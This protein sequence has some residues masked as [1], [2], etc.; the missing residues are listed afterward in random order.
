MSSPG[1]EL[2]HRAPVDVD[3]D[4]LVARAVVDRQQVVGRDDERARGQRVRR[5]EG[6]D[7][8]R[9]APGQHRPAVGEVVARRALRR[10]DD[11]A[12][13][14]HAA[15]LLA[16]ER[17]GEV[18]DAE[19]RLAVHGDVVHRRPRP[20]GAPD[21]DAGQLERLEL[22]RERAVEVG[23]EPVRVERGEEA[24][25]AEVDRE[26]RHAGARVLAQRG[27]DRAVA[28]HHDAEVDVAR[29]RRVDSMP[30]AGREAVLARLLGVEAQRHARARG[31]GDQRGERRPRCRPPGGA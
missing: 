6:D 31:R 22:A 2:D 19:A 29:E 20:L 11:E 28:A 27:E 14:A 3:L 16:R 4:R 1:A 21:G 9:H 24:D 10:G 13:A 30:V 12:V 18:G 23:V 7:E 5:D 8:A 26:H 25:L 17:V 15:D